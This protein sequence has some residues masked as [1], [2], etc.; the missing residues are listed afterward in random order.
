MLLFIYLF[1]QE[2]V[3]ITSEW[4]EGAPVPKMELNFSAGSTTRQVSLKL[5][6]LNCWNSVY[7]LLLKGKCSRKLIYNLL[8]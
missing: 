6:H 4:E 3:V 5:E 8:K 1:G 7:N 2:Q